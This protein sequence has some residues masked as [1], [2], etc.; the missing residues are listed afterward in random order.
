MGEIFVEA[1]EAFNWLG[2]LTVQLQQASPAPTNRY[3]MQL[4]AGVLSDCRACGYFRH[5]FP[6]RIMRYHGSLIA[7]AALHSGSVGELGSDIAWGQYLTWCRCH[8]ELMAK[9]ITTLPAVSVIDTSQSTQMIVSVKKK[10][11][12]R[13]SQ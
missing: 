3:A 1:G 9:T 10:R 11:Y 13:S 7:G 12:V 8:I 5:D 6:R 4:L 2:S